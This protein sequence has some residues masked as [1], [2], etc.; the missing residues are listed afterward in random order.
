VQTDLKKLV[1]YS[2]VSH[3]GFVVL[4]IF[5]FTLEGAAGA[6]IQMVN[7]GLSTGALFLMVGIIYERTHK[8]GVTD[9]GG[10]AKTMPLYA[11]V[12]VILVLSSVGLPG[13]N[14]FVGEFLVIAGA[15]KAR[16]L[17]AFVSALGVILAAVYLLSMVRKVF[18]GESNANLHGLP[19]L[20]WRETAVFLPLLLFI[21]VIGVYPAPFLEVSEGALKAILEGVAP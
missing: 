19:D 20:T 7:H 12:S 14:G 21:V 11:T 3:M 1:A 17:Y 5:S 18:W 16:P 6:T 8:R 13:L 2:S 15:M 10:L 4:G 9:F